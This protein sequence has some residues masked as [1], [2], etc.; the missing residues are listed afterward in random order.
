MKILIAY[1]GSYFGNAI[2]DDLLYAGLPESAKAM[3]ITVV[4]PESFLIGKKYEDVVGWLG[5]R[6]IEARSA[7]RFAGN[8]I[9]SAFPKW[10]L[11][12]EARLALPQKELVDGVRT[13]GTDLVI[14]GQHGRANSKKAGIG[15]IAKRLLKKARCSV[16]IARARIRSQS[17]PPRV[18]VPLCAPQNHD[19]VEEAVIA[20][21]WPRGT[22]IKLL[23]SVGL[24][25]DEMQLVSSVLDARVR[26]IKDFLRSFEKK[27]QSANLLVSSEIISSFTTSDV[28][29][30]ARQWGA[31]CVMVGYREMN[32]FERVFCSDFAA[33]IAAS[34]ECSV[35]V[36]RGPIRYSAANPD[37]TSSVAS[38][39]FPLV[40]P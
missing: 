38:K 21:A 37:F 5:Y 36:A 39:D 26:A 11:C 15:R 20:R 12:Y 8:R 6:M 33:R 17:R 23:A 7:A 9:Q 29:N 28:N 14:I 24:F 27:F 2:L 13:W 34:A 4:E 31:D 32:F 35:E 1:D 22:E 30:T 16:R 3:V 25:L 19:A 40:V 18:I 10:D